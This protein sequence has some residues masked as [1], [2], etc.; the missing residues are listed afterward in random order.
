VS[1]FRATV[2]VCMCICTCVCICGCGCGWVCLNVCLYVCMRIRVSCV[3]V[4]HVCPSVLH[5][6]DAVFIFSH[7]PRCM[8]SL[9]LRRFRYSRVRYKFRTYSA[10]CQ[11]L[12]DH[13]LTYDPRKRIPASEVRR[14][15]YFDE[16]PLPTQ[17]SMM[18]TFPPLHREE[19]QVEYLRPR[20]A[21]P[22][23]AT[24]ELSSQANRSVVF[25]RKRSRVR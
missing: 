10:H 16:R 21:S 22:Q 14:H 11:E 19:E 23:R 7:V 8:W 13:L 25:G 12:L 1:S 9:P 3:S 5:P 17:K 15:V 4:C 20:S 6:C 18:P 2:C 24:S